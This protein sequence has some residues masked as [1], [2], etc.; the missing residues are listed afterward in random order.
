MADSEKAK[1][2]L[3]QNLSQARGGETL[4][5]LA[6]S[7]PSS[8]SAA[9][10]GDEE[11]DEDLE[12]EGASFSAT[13][14]TPTGDEEG[15]LSFA[16]DPA[17]LERIRKERETKL[18]EA[19][20][21]VSGEFDSQVRAPE[22]KAPDPV[23]DEAKKRLATAPTAIAT[24]PVPPAPTSA[25]A[26]VIPAPAPAPT[27]APATPARKKVASGAHT[28]MAPAA[29]PPSAPTTGSTPVVAAPGAV[30]QVAS[31]IRNNLV[32]LLIMSVVVG[33]FVWIVA[34]YATRTATATPT[35]TPEVTAPT[36]PIIAPTDDLIIPEE[37]MPSETPTEEE[38]L[39]DGEVG[40]LVWEEA[41][42]VD[43]ETCRNRFTGLADGV[44]P[45][46]ARF[47][48]CEAGEAVGN[49]ICACEIGVR[50]R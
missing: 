12:V 48:R 28:L 42:D 3:G 44:I 2:T 14:N 29:T 47:F 7:L 15:S 40:Q 21:R 31:L 9:P 16:T 1:S 26:V 46:G 35:A 4:A 6:A 25:P 36:A 13:N 23:L 38:Y 49:N 18:E 20:E 10:T 11:K 43:P 50:L 24:T 30:A 27:P 39:F 5:R 33:L 32:P 17:E 19:A 37:M 45:D 34:T 41:S 8:A 22:P